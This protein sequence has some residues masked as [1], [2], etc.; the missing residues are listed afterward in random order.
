MGMSAGRTDG[1]DIVLAVRQG[2]L[3]RRLVD[4]HR[5]GVLVGE[6]KETVIPRF[7]GRTTVS[8]ILGAPRLRVAA[9][10]GNP[11][12]V[13]FPIEG[14]SVT[15]RAGTVALPERG[16]AI[17]VDAPLRVFGLPCEGY[18]RPVRLAVDFSARESKYTV[19]MEATPEATVTGDAPAPSPAAPWFQAVELALKQRL[20]RESADTDRAGHPHP[21]HIVDISFPPFDGGLRPMPPVVWAVQRMDHCPTG[22][23]DIFALLCSLVENRTPPESGE[24]SPPLIPDGHEAAV[25][26]SDRVVLDR[27]VGAPLGLCIGVGKDECRRPRSRSRRPTMLIPDHSCFVGRCLI[28]LRAAVELREGAVVVRP[29]ARLAPVEPL[30]AAFTIEATADLRLCPRIQEAPEG[31]PELVFPPAVARAEGRISCNW[32][33][34]ALGAAASLASA[35]TPDTVPGILSY[36]ILP[37]LRARLEFPKYKPPQDSPRYYHTDGQL[38]ELLRAFRWTGEAAFSPLEAVFPDDLI[39]AG[40]LEG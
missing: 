21:Y 17:V 10:D 16:S 38:G 28:R 27:M 7:A 24:E 39:I 14:G 18:D 12:R 13:V 36:L 11:M 29:E 32:A 26:I 2:A 34:Y 33:L 8:L 19:E 37:F 20:T 30:T 3:N 35:G 6:L 5:K 23:E 31:G 25:V 22:D 15:S 4:L 1:W 40:R 9:L